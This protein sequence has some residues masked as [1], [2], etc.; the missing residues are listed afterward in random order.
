MKLVS[1]YLLAGWNKSIFK[2]D[3]LFAV[4]KIV[5]MYIQGLSLSGIFDLKSLKNLKY[6]LGIVGNP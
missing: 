3:Y 2:P 5:V 1:K 6:S 4:S